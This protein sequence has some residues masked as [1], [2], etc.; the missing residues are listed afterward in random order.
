[1]FAPEVAIHEALLRSPGRTMD[2]DEADVF[3]VPVYSTCTAL[4]CV[5]AHAIKPRARA[6]GV[7]NRTNG[8][9]KIVTRPGWYYWK[10]CGT[11]WYDDA[12]ELLR[13]A[14]THWAS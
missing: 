6:F 3:Y 2:P 9:N 4:G 13:D 7:R 11:C 5:P 14:A 12:K 8:L 1:M 10:K